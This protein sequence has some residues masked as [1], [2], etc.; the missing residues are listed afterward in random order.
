[1]PFGVF[2]PLIKHPLTDLGVNKFLADWNPQLQKSPT[3]RGGRAL[4]G[5]A[6]KDRWGRLT[7]ADHDHPWRGYMLEMPA[8]LALYQKTESSAV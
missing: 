4:P 2:Q 6:G 3:T 1:M 8:Y 5:P 7:L